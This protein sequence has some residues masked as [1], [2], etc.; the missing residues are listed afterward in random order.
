RQ[1]MCD[2][3]VDAESHQLSG[4]AGKTLRLASSPAILDGEVLAL[5]VPAITQSLAECVGRSRVL[6]RSHR[7]EEP[8]PNWPGHRCALATATTPRAADHQTSRT[9]ANDRA[10]EA[11]ESMLRWNSL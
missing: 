5:D 11:V 1:A 4:E 3:D 8:D 10:T 9:S 6:R 2:D 7:T